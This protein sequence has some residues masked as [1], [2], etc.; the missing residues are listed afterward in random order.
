[1]YGRPAR[2]HKGR[3][4]SLIELSRSVFWEGQRRC[5]VRFG[6]RSVAT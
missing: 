1:M 6:S 5:G 4:C 3:S 2:P